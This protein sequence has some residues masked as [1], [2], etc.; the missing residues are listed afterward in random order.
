MR[1]TAGNLRPQLS[2][3]TDG[4]T[5]HE[6]MVTSALPR[7]DMPSRSGPPA[8]VEPPTRGGELG[9]MMLTVDPYASRPAGVLVEF[10]LAGQ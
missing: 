7:V 2:K 4:L 5:L 3:V 6:R 10:L 8:R 1:R 9:T